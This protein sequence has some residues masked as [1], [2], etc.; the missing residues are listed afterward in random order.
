MDEILDPESYEQIRKL[1][2]DVYIGGAWGFVGGLCLSVGYHLVRMSLSPGFKSSN[3]NNIVAS[4]F[5]SGAFGSFV[6]SHYGGKLSQYNFSKKLPLM[7]NPIGQQQTEYTKLQSKHRDEIVQD[8]DA[9]FARRNEA[10][11]QRVGISSTTDTK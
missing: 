5:L 10:I 9:S 3:K 6:G 11:R 7:M 8:M 4:V 1:R 2:R